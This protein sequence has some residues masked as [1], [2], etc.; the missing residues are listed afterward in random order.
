MSTS[1]SLFL[2]YLVAWLVF[3]HIYFHT[4]SYQMKLY[5]MALCSKYPTITTF[6]VRHVYYVYF[7]FITFM[8]ITFFTFIEDMSA[9]CR[10]LSYPQC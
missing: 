8:F 1:Y 5:N 10:I 7:M 3:L 4:H 6:I 2:V 9:E